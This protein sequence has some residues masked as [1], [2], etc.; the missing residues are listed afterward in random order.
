MPQYNTISSQLTAAGSRNKSF[1]LGQSLNTSVT[2]NPNCYRS[3]DD[4]FSTALKNRSTELF[5]NLQTFQNKNQNNLNQENSERTKVSEI[6]FEYA[7]YKAYQDQ[8]DLLFK[9]GYRRK[10]QADQF[11]TTYSQRD[12]GKVQIQANDGLI[13]RPQTEQIRTY[14]MLTYQKMKKDFDNVKNADPEVSSHDIYNLNLRPPMRFYDTRAG[15]QHADAYGL[16]QLRVGGAPPDIIFEANGNEQKRYEYDPHTHEVQDNYEYLK[17][18]HSGSNF[19]HQSMKA[20]FFLSSMQHAVYDVSKGSLTMHQ[21]QSLVGIYATS[22]NKDEFLAG[23][24]E[25]LKSSNE[26][27]NE[28]SKLFYKNN[29]QAAKLQPI[30]DKVEKNPKL[31]EDMKWVYDDMK[32]GGQGDLLYRGSPTVFKEFDKNGNPQLTSGSPYDEYQ[33][34]NNYWWFGGWSM[35]SSIID[36]MEGDYVH[37]LGLNV[38]ERFG[39]TKKTEEKP[40]LEKS[41]SY[42][43]LQKLQLMRDFK[44]P[45]SKGYDELTDEQQA[46][47]E[48][49]KDGLEGIEK[50]KLHGLNEVDRHADEGEESNNDFGI[51][52]K[53]GL[54]DD[55]YEQFHEAYEGLGPLK[56]DIKAE[57]RLEL[58]EGDP[59]PDTTETNEGLNE[60]LSGERSD[61]SKELTN[62][63]TDY[64]SNESTQSGTDSSKTQSSS[65]SETIGVDTL[66]LSAG[67]APFVKV[68]NNSDSGTTASSDSLELTS[69]DSTPPTVFVDSS[70]STTPSSNPFAKAAE[71]VNALNSTAGKLG[72]SS[73]DCKNIAA[74]KATEAATPAPAPAPAPT[75]TTPA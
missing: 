71:S 13:H 19:T 18:D 48:G 26:Q 3:V 33:P 73:A 72:T 39:L 63:G 30:T 14:E 4:K 62:D 1:L 37:I 42:D 74:V 12:T 75:P 56:E 44:D 54:I 5:D 43:S 10:E 64:L 55:L 35:V 41:L 52:I 15:R 20:T 60:D 31:K 23:C 65:D 58:N 67:E 2:W 27:A 17:F 47:F 45:K 59:K 25:R 7:H 49:L 16:G 29:D 70:K 46:Q 36:I 6:T 50:D 24:K 8:Q 40:S 51:A 34:K 61:L 28:L 22:D 38:K 11:Y 9:N 21:S 69:G 57:D 68:K 53:E 66:D 32:P